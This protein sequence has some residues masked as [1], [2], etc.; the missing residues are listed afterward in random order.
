MPDY[1]TFNYN[2]KTWLS[3]SDNE[4]SKNIKIYAPINGDQCWGISPPCTISKNYLEE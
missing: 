4:S 3:F 1:E 2:P